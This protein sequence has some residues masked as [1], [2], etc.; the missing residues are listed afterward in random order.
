MKTSAYND[1]V[2][3][4]CKNPLYKKAA[5]NNFTLSINECAN[6]CCGLKDGSIVIIQ[7]IAWHVQLNDFVI[8]GKKFLQ[9]M[10]AYDIPCVSSLL[11]TYIVSKS[12]LSQTR[13]WPLSNVK[14]KFFIMPYGSDNKYVIL[15]LLHNEN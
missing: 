5:C 2:P 1:V 7:Q 8:V 15:P 3:D 13:M 9:K 10:N 4:G 11:D 6:N 12:T 14:Q